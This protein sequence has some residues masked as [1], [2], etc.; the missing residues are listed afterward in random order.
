M[1]DG[2]YYGLD[3]TVCYRVVWYQ[4]VVSLRPI[5][6]EFSARLGGFL[7]DNTAEQYSL[8]YRLQVQRDNTAARRLNREE[9]TE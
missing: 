1:L 6:A 4:I 5:W 3:G 8:W 9:E 7:Q 2:C